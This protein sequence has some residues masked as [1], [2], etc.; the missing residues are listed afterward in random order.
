MPN[1][2]IRVGEVTL[3]VREV[4]RRAPAV[5][6]LHYGGGNLAMWEPVVPF[7]RD[8][9]HILLVD[10]RGHGRSDRPAND[11]HI[12]D[13]ADDVAG[14]VDRLDLDQ[15]H[16][17]GSSLGAEVGLSLAARYPNRVAS[18][19]CDGALH[20]EYGPYGMWQGSEAGF[21]EHA[22]QTIEML[23]TRDEPVFP[24]VD[25][26]VEES[27][28]TLAPHGIWN[29][30]MEAVVRYGAIRIDPTGYAGCWRRPLS[31][32]Y[33]GHYL[34]L[35]FEEYYRRIECPILLVPDESI[36]R[37]DRAR[38]AMEGLAALARNCTIAQ[39]EGWIHPYGWVV[40]P[41]AV[42][43]VVLDFLKRRTPR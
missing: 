34:R 22:E 36:L 10:L 13:M 15:A 9:Y 37:N 25:A 27:R 39:V 31:E 3:Q 2:R 43:R 18:L 32:E 42:C 6:F 4:V 14:L 12:D 30:A 23:R 21:A 38:T 26:L 24:T 28:R 11:Y 33:T 1:R 29:G 35:R 20:S 40:D 7:F 17:V 5:V 41:E 16:V 8:R 19:V